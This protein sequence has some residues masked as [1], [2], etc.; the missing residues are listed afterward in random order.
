MQERTSDWQIAASILALLAS[1]LLGAIIVVAWNFDR[2][3]PHDNH[4]GLLETI[5]P[6]NTWFINPFQHQAMAEDLNFEI[7][8]CKLCGKQT[9]FAQIGSRTTKLYLIPSV[10]PASTIKLGIVNAVTIPTKNYFHKTND[11]K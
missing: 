5:T 10:D 6:E 2:Q 11:S 4:K 7:G 9:H 3:P 1:A 8:V